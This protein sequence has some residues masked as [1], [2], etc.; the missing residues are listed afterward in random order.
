M[1]LIRQRISSL[2]IVGFVVIVCTGVYAQPGFPFANKQPYTFSAKSTSTTSSHDTLSLVGQWSWGQ[3]LAVVV[4]GNYA[5]IGNGSLLQILDISNP[6][7]P[8]TVG[9]VY[10]GSE[11][12]GLVVSGN[13]AYMTPGFSIID[14]SDVTNPRV[15]SNISV[16]STTAALAVSGEYTYI[17]DI[18]G[19][20]Y[21]INVSD[22]TQPYVVS[23]YPM[24]HTQ[25]YLVGSIVIVDTVLYAGT[26][27]GTSAD[28]FDIS[29]PLSPVHI[30]NCFGTRGVFAVQGHC[31]YLAAT[32][33][34]DEL[35]VYDI[36]KPLNPRFING[37][38]LRSFPVIISV[39]DSL[40]YIC[41]ANAG[42]EVVDV[43]DT[44]N[45]HVLAQMP[46][47]YNFPSGVD[48]GPYDLSLGSTIACI[49]SIN[50]L[51]IVDI[52][53]L[54]MLTT[55]SFLATGWNITPSIVADTLH[56]AFVAEMYG[57]LQIIDFS[58]A[59]SPRLIG[60]YTPNEAV[61]DV[62]VSK[63]VAYLLCDSDLVILD[64][65][66]LSTP[67]LMGPVFM[68]AW[69]Y[70]TPQSTLQ[71]IPAIYTPLMSQILYCP[72]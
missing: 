40:V 55:E 11:I 4:R 58:T 1:E 27:D 44:S 22:P 65:S 41:E 14:V 61:R 23:G 20:I 15:V 26:V 33:P 19:N 43:A 62:A 2:L 5:L 16:P 56:H 57:G 47:L 42:F 18:Y 70:M 72:S 37:A 54:P 28:I 31:L 63:N 68:G 51:W 39:R 67:V 34:Y 50:G 66:K 8:L 35:L 12:F 53:K 71:E 36:S 10:V 9:E 7:V 59:S 38:N 24:M 49:A 45:I 52:S 29:T 17:G 32:S 6:V 69:H 60:Q 46:Y 30:L 25:G 13:Y 3:S 48:V 21:T 64:V